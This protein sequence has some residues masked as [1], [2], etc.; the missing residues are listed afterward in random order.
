MLGDI[1]GEEEGEEGEAMAFTSLFAEEGEEEEGGYPFE[2]EGKGIQEMGR[3]LYDENGKKRK[4]HPKHR[5]RRD[6]GSLSLSTSYRAQRSRAFL[7]SSLPASRR[8]NC[9][10][11][12]LDNQGMCV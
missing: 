10:F 1:M 3:E 4:R 7:S 9:N 12:G 11:V 6:D 5:E 8:V 2:G